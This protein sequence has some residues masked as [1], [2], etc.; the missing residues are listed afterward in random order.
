MSGEDE[1]VI[2]CRVSTTKQSTEGV[3]IDAQTKECE[4][5]CVKNDK[6]IIGIF[7]DL[8]KSGCAKDDEHIENKLI[9]NIDGISHRSEVIQALLLCCKKPGTTFVCYSISRLSRN[10]TQALQIYNFLTK[11]KCHI[12]CLTEALDSSNKFG[13]V[14]LQMLGMFSEL[15][16][17]MIKTR[18]QSSIDNKKASGQFLG[19]IPYGFKL[20]DNESGNDLIEDPEEK[21]V[22]E[23]MKE[24]RNQPNKHGK[25]TT[26][27]EEIADR[28]NEMGIKTKNGAKWRHNIVSR[29]INR[30]PPKRM[31]GN[32]NKKK[33]NEQKKS[34]DPLEE[35]LESLKELEIIEEM[36][37]EGNVS[38]LDTE[39]VMNILSERMK[40]A[41]NEVDEE[42]MKDEIIKLSK[43]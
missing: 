11:H 15:E 43:N 19:R 16:A 40:R 29:I 26:S 22:I 37:K 39:S 25:P 17:S 35:R 28:L 30:G 9:K 5:W 12:Y 21:R 13:K 2:Y 27:Y 1:A 38:G 10:L 33:L 23:M 32:P 18:V 7:Q 4:K 42:E 31:A 20:K 34:N 8:G 14:H 24:W 36:E 41:E 6:K 3:S